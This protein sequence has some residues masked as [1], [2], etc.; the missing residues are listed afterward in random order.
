M[1]D[2]PDIGSLPMG[3]RLT[4]GGAEFRVWAPQRRLVEVE[5]LD[6][7][8][9]PFAM[10]PEATGTWF[11]RLPVGAGT[12]YRYRLDGGA[13]FPDP[14][15]RFQP[16]GVH[17]PSELVDV[18]QLH[19]LTRDWRGLSPEGLAIYECH[20]GTAT[21]AG[22][23]DAL[24]GRLEYLRELGVNAIELMPLAE[25]P[26]RWGWGYDG[27]QLFAVSHNYGGP[28]ALARFVDAAH[29]AGLGVILDVVYNHL[30]PEGNYLGQFSAYYFTDRYR[31]PWGDALNYDG[32]GSPWTRKLVVDN[33]R[34]WLRDFRVDGL[35]LDATAQIHDAS[36]RHI[37]GELT[38]AARAS[39]PAG[40]SVVLIA[41]NSANDYRY[42]EPAGNGGWGFD[43][44][45]ADDF[46]HELRRFLAGDAEGWFQDYEGTLE[47]LAR[48]IN[49]GFL[50]EGQ[51]STFG[52][53]PRGAPARSQPARCF[54]YCIQNHDQVGNRAVGDR[55]SESV[56]LDRYRV[57]SALFLLLPYTPLLFMGQEF[58]AS[59]PFQFFSDFGPELAESVTQGRQA[60]FAGYSAF[61]RLD[62]PDPQD[63]A[64]FLRSKL[65]FA[66]AQHAPGVGMLTLY[67]AL[68][69]L[70]ATDEVL[71]LQDRGRLDASAPTSSLLLVSLGGGRLLVANFGPEA[72]LELEQGEVLFQSNA[73]EY[74]GDGRPATFTG[75]RAKL[76]AHTAILVAAP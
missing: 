41:E 59:S 36:P 45:W 5:L 32:P 65:D 22:T 15:S 47:E 19:W 67:R 16:L 52:G 26:G 33:A 74:G 66:E 1:L 30:G 46:H 3:A 68:L 35:R 14:Y 53:G 61:T 50:Y 55:L 72:E 6:S 57:A 8:A 54:Q 27:V 34:Q 76:P 39:V 24:I 17:G 23:L 18:D 44:V 58:A 62:L 37:L 51:W 69:H 38:T 7:G 13:S 11:V 4:Q 56:D 10:E 12:R 60:E 75:G 21:E 70:R 42:V 29:G 48:T 20:V 49:Q 40:R 2:H 43:L 73:R 63:E 25:A 28:L 71:S 9:P 31:T 64:T